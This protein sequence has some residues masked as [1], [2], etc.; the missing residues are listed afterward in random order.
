MTPVWAVR[1]VGLPYRDRGRDRSGVDC[2]GL[3][4]LVLAE[5]AAIEV[6]SFATY[7]D[8][9]DAAGVTATADGARGSGR[10]Q[11][12][13]PGREQTFDIVELSTAMRTADG[14]TI[15]PMHAGIVV[16]PGWLLHVERG[17]DA[18][19]TRY[20]ENQAMRRRVLGFWRYRTPA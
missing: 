12:I 7:A 16:A 11:P 20:R 1:Y 19:L 13:E 14:W 4:R 2:W 5:Q 9:D 6:P 15:G 8:G 10:W 17:S 3:A 18:V